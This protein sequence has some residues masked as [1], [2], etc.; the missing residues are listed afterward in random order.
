M[1]RKCPAC[2]SRECTFT[3]SVV[4]TNHYIPGEWDLYL[5][6]NCECYFINNPPIGDEMLKYYPSNA[7]YT[8]TVPQNDNFILQKIYNHYFGID[9]SIVS[10]ILYLVFKDSVNILPPKTL[11]NTILDFGCGNG[12]LL[13]R[14]TKYGYKCT[15]Y[16]VDENSIRVASSQGYEVLTGDIHDIKT[17]KKFDIII[18]NQVV[19]HL[20]EPKNVLLH[21]KNF[22]TDE[23][24]IIISVPFRDNVDF[25]YYKDAWSS[26]QAPTHLMH[27]NNKSLDKLLICCG[28]KV[29]K[30][31]YASSFSTLKKSYL[32]TNYKNAKILGYS[33]FKFILS[34][35][36]V[37]FGFKKTIRITVYCNKTET[38]KHETPLSQ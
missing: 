27:F 11:H 2:D 9:N 38:S 31:Q 28:L 5:C 14:F 26:F 32:K 29:I 23:G 34:S 37:L 16:E 3:K 19:E 7:Y 21:L 35:F 30:R 18:L 20:I 12:L 10:Q 6:N 33:H 4:D 36:L 22:L 24:Q 25:E 15:G 1:M 13:N 17:D 8:H